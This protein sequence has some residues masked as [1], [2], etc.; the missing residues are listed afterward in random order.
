MS[1]K[2]W[3]DLVKIALIGTDRGRPASE[4]VDFLRN[5]GIDQDSSPS[6]QILEGAAIIHHLQKAGFAL[7]AFEDA[8]PEP[9]EEKDEQICNPKSSHHLKLILSGAFE[10]A[11]DE[12]VEHLTANKKCLPPESLPALLNE[13]LINPGLWLRIRPALG[14]RGLWLMPLHP[15]WSSLESRPDLNNWDTG[16]QKERLEILSFLRKEE[17][18]KAVELLRKT[19]GEDSPADRQ[20]FLSAL[21]EGMSIEDEPFLE[22]CLLDRRKEVRQLAARLLARIG[23]SGLVDRLWDWLADYLSLD[24]EGKI[25]MKLPEELPEPLKRAGIEPS[26]KSSF[27]GGMKA[28]WVHQVIARIPPARWVREWEKEPREVLNLFHN[29]HWAGLLENAVT[30]AALFHEDV[31]WAAAIIRHW[32]RTDERRAW[33]GPSGKKLMLQLSDQAFNGIVLSWIEHN[34]QLIEENSV[35]GQLLTLASHRWEDRL[36]ILVVKGF[37]NWMDGARSYHWNVWHYTRILK[38]AAYLCSP[39]LIDSLKPGWPYKSPIWPRWQTEVERFMD[40]LQFRKKMIE[41]LKK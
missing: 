29:H 36:A 15:E 10:P 37:Q 38:A 22:E 12:F 39:A 19:W 9:V 6:R 4:T 24:P 28:G 17:P 30:E 11:L 41:E 16:T 14:A 35:A 40:V 3:K 2:I 27:Q 21:E 18:A 13:C 5:Q 7:V 32:M 34:D 20:A 31:D 23:N 33:S 1:D 25:E 8:L 26:T